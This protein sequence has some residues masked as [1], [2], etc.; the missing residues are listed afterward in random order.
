[1]RDVAGLAGRRQRPRGTRMSSDRGAG[2]GEV[3][4]QN[5]KLT[6]FLFL[7]TNFETTNIQG[8]REYFFRLVFSFGLF[9][10]L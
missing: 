5:G 3:T 8:W 2:M 6:L 4:W 9:F 7:L 10:L 1:V